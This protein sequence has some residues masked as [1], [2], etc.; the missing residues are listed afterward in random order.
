M[1]SPEL[2]PTAVAPDDRAQRTLAQPSCSVSPADAPK[3]GLLG[4]DQLAEVS[5]QTKRGQ[6]DP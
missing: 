6:V 2:V 5:V 1:G 4:V 3:A